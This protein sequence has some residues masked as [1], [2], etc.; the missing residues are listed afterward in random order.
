MPAVRVIAFA[1]LRAPQLG[2]L[3]K[4]AGQNFVTAERMNIIAVHQAASIEEGC[5]E[6]EKADNMEIENHMVWRCPLTHRG[7]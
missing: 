2:C 5:R 1:T 4:R 6:R 3:V 7:C